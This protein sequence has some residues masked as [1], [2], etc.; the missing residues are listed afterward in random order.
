M[1]FLKVKFAL[2]FFVFLLNYDTLSQLNL[3]DSTIS[4]PWFAVHYG[5][6]WSQKDLL[7]KFG[8]LNHLGFFAGYK[9]NKNWIWGI[10]AN[11]I[12]SE[13]V[14]LTGLY[15]HLRDSNGN[16]S[17]VNGDIAI[18]VTQARGLNA[19]LSIGKVIPVLSVNKNSGIYIHAGLGYLTHK[20]RTETQEH[21]VPQIELEYRKGYDRLVSGINFHQFIGY[22]FLGNTSLIKFYAGFYAQQGFTQNLRDIFFDQPEIPVSQATMKDFQAGFRLGWFIPIYKRKPKDFYFN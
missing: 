1:S 11:F 13:K 6:N 2:L 20:I 22:A 3:R 5:G 8:Y 16:I 21:V 14:K 18:V 10:D 12:F 4:M 17:D 7:Q 15:D 19:N 9:T